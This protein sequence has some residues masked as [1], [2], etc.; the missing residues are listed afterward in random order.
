MEPLFT[1]SHANPNPSSSPLRPVGTAGQGHSMAR[2][3]LPGALP[4]PHPLDPA[5][6]PTLTILGLA[7]GPDLG[8]GL[9]FLG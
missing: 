8:R 7:L 2:D 6:A 3:Q 4:F 5:L 9:P 1:R